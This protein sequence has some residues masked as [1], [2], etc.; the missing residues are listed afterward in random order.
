MLRIST[1]TEREIMNLEAINNNERENTKTD[2][3]E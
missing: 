3:R 1:K 2:K